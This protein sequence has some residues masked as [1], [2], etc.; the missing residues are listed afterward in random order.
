MQVEYQFNFDN[1]QDFVSFLNKH[2]E[3]INMMGQ[4]EDR[5]TDQIQRQVQNNQQLPDDFTFTAQ[6]YVSMMKMD[7]EGMENME[8]DDR[9]TVNKIQDD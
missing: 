6:Q 9:V 7:K 1:Y 5:L 3:T 8:S 4:G 2:E